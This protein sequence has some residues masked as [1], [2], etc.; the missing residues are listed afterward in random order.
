MLLN[1]KL[2]TAGPKAQSEEWKNLRIY[3][4]ERERPIVFGASIAAAC[5][6]FSPYETP[7]EVYKVARQEKKAWEPDEKQ[8]ERMRFGQRMEAVAIEEYA[9][10]KR[11]CVET[12]HPMYLSMVHSFMGATP[13]ATAYHEGDGCEI[14]DQWGIEAKNSNWRMFDDSGDDQHKYGKADTDE[15]PS[16]AFFQ[17]QQQMAVLGL[18]RV[19]LPVL[20]NGNELLIYKVDRSEEFIAAIIRAEA[21]LFERIVNG[22]PP[23][24]DFQ[25]ETTGKLLQ[26]MYGVEVGTVAYLSAEDEEIWEGVIQAKAE[27]KELEEKIEAGKNRMLHSMGEAEVA[28]FPSCQF[29]LKRS[30]IPDSIWTEDDVKSIVIGAVKRRGHIRL[31]QRKP[32]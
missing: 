1:P 28:T 29:E 17:A 2:A 30:K 9:N 11:C 27:L 14:L 19:D 5:C 16:I 23:E 26:E 25:H 10:Q 21:E 3:D 8:A 32:K 4:P 20:K 15:V 12:E 22:D 24:P 7:L 18:Q 13:D 31:T 6:G